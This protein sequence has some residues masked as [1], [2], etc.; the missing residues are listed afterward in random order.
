MK[1]IALLNV[2]RDMNSDRYRDLITRLAAAVIGPPYRSNLLSQSPAAILLLEGLRSTLSQTFFVADSY[3]TSP[4]NDELHRIR[5]LVKKARY[6]A[7]LAS[8]VLGTPA[9]NLASLFEEVQ[10][11]LGELHD[12]VVTLKVFDE[13]L[14]EMVERDPA[15]RI[16]ASRMRVHRHLER[17]IRALKSRWRRP[18]DRAR[19]QSTVFLDERS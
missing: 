8:S 5:I 14:N 13:G 11:V 10:T 19:H 2:H 17:E 7:S 15:L 9:K 12:R 3:G 16:D 18:L 6:R 4:T 1:N